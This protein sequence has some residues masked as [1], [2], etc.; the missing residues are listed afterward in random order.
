MSILTPEEMYTEDTGKEAMVMLH[1]ANGYD[2]HMVAS[3]DYVHWLGIQ[4]LA[5]HSIDRDLMKE[6]R[7]LK[8]IIEMQDITINKLSTPVDGYY[9]GI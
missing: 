2:V 1:D 7:R 3:D 5:M 6:N 4:L 9:T 8:G